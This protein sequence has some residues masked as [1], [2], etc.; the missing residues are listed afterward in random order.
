MLELLAYFDRQ[1]NVDTNVEDKPKGKQKTTVE[2][3]THKKLILIKGIC[4]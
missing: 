4:P 3:E 1:M 2:D